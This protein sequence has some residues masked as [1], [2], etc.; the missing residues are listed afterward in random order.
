MT[1]EDLETIKAVLAAGEKAFPNTFDDTLEVNYDKRLS[2][3]TLW[4]SD[5]DALVSCYGDYTNSEEDDMAFIIAAKLALPALLKLVE[6]VEELERNNKALNDSCDHLKKSYDSYVDGYNRLRECISKNKTCF[7]NMGIDFI[8][9][10]ENLSIN[11]A[12]VSEEFRLLNKQALEKD[13]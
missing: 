8:D 2:A 11:W 13:E 3:L 12:D 6:R 9:G 1:E 4:G 7:E 5:G 10:H